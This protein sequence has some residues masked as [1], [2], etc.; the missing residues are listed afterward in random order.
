MKVKKHI[1][2]T[3]NLNNVPRSGIYMQI[4]KNKIKLSA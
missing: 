4:N 2:N 3:T 1:Y